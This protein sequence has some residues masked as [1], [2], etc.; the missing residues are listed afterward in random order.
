MVATGTYHNVPLELLPV[1][2]ATSVAREKKRLDA[3]ARHDQERLGLMEDLE[4]VE[5]RMQSEA[6]SA[7]VRRR[8]AAIRSQLAKGGGAPKRNKSVRFAPGVKRSSKH[9]VMR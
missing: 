1:R 3:E 5:R 8:L 9:R 7:D 2:V 6:F 4:R